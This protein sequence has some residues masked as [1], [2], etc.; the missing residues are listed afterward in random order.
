MGFLSSLGNLFFG[1]GNGGGGG[2]TA[3]VSDKAI[4]HKDRSTPGLYTSADL[5]RTW[6]SQGLIL[7]P[8]QVA[9]SAQLAKQAK[10]QVGYAVKFA[11]NVKAIA[12]SETEIVSAFCDAKGHVAGENLKQHKAHNKLFNQ[13]DKVQARYAMEGYKRQQQYQELQQ[14]MAVQLSE[15]QQK[16][17]E[18]RHLAGW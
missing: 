8:E 6:E 14:K 3:P 2:L 10:I 17:N 11:E 5:V 18:A 16:Q 1:G 4:T 13:L 7:S 12:T 15:L 9:Q